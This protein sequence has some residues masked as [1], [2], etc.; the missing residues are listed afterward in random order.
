M[1]RRLITNTQRNHALE[2]ATVSILLGR[3]TGTVRLAGRAMPDGFYIYGNIPTA[4]IE[5]SAHEGLARLQN[6][7]AYL[8]VTPLCGTNIAVAGILTGVLSVMSMGQSKRFSRLPNVFMATMFGIVVAQPLGR[9]VQKYVTTRP[10]LERTTIVG[11]T[12]SLGGWVHRV[13]TATA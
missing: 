6:G 4:A 9:L 2:H 11:V 10:D 7:E 12:R 5:S 13:K 1:L 3:L 8:A